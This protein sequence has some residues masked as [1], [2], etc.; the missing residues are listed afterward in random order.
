MVMAVTIV[1]VSYSVFLGSSLFLLSFM[2]HVYQP[3]VKAR[4]LLELSLSLRLCLLLGPPHAL[5]F[6]SLMIVPHGLLHVWAQTIIYVFNAYVQK[7]R[8]QQACACITL[9][10]A[11]VTQIPSGL[12]V[13]SHACSSGFDRLIGVFCCCFFALS[14]HTVFTFS[15]AMLSYSCENMSYSTVRFSY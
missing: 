8:W 11:N 2:F 7:R 13:I 12:N 5:L 3:E 10:P 15:C 14:Q 4:L 9:C 1:I 6:L